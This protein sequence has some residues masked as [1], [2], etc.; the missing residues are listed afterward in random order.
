ML[1][2]FSEPKV[3]NLLEGVLNRIQYERCGLCRGTRL[4]TVNGEPHLASFLVYRQVREPRRGGCTVHI[5]I[6][7]EK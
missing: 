1:D 6:G 7:M 4:M 3:T 2:P 5:G